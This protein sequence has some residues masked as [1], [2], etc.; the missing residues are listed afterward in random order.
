MVFQVVSV[1][2]IA[3]LALA[4]PAFAGAASGRLVHG[5]MPNGPVHV[6]FRGGVN[7]QHSF[8]RV[9]CCF[10][11]NSTFLVG[12]LAA[13]SYGYP[14]TPPVYVQPAYDPTQIEPTTMAAIA[15][16]VAPAPPKVCYVGGC[17]HL[18]GGGTSEPPHW[19]WVPNPPAI[20]P[21]LPER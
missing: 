19:V 15:A 14:F 6:G 5:G 4:A 12:G 7:G 3:V 10:G 16:P 2:I 13:P 17:Y 20:P 1:A 21:S 8:Q 11:A 18:Q 9:A